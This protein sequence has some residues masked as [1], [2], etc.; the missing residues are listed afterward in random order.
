VL[1][2][3]PAL[4]LAQLVDKLPNLKFLGILAYDGGVQHVTGFQKRKEEALKNFEAAVMSYDMM[5]KSGL[6]LEIFSGGGTGTYDIMPGV[7]G[8]TDVQVGSYVFMDCQYIVIGGS[9]NEKVYDD[10]DP[11]LTIM[12]TIINSNYP[13]RLITDAGAK[14]LTLNQPKAFV[15]GEPDFTYNAGSDEYGTATFEKSSREY[16][17][18]DKLELI[19]PHCDPVVNLYDFMY[20]IR[21]DK[22]ES[23]LPILARG[24]S[25]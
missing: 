11:S 19:V 6:N 14:S 24:K 8:F 7:P 4:A 13:G 25:Q 1:P 12:T 20:G 18:G 22:V 3:E 2:G 23:I 21:N 16:K 5:K 10:F 9:K 15:V 17:V